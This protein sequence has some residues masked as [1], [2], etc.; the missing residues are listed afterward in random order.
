MTGKD[1]TG[2]AVLRKVRFRSAPGMIRLG[3]VYCGGGV[4]EFTVWAPYARSLDVFLTSPEG[5]HVPLTA[6]PRGYWRAA[7][8]DVYP[9]T[10]YFYRL[11]GEAERPDPASRFQPCGVHGPS[12]VT[13]PGSFPWED[14]DWKGLEADDLVFY[15]LHTGLFTPEGSFE[16]LIPHIP[17]LKDLG[18]TA[19]EL[20]P[21]AQFP[22]GRNWGYDGVY[23][24]APQ[25]TYGGPEGLKTLVNALHRNGLAVFLDVVYNHLGPEGNYTHAF[26][27][28][29]TA[30]HRTPWGEALNFEGPGSDEVR[31]FFIQN[32]LYWLEEFHMDGL[33]LDAV[34]GIV[35]RRAVHFLADLVDAVHRVTAQWDRK[36]HLVAESDLNDTR[37]I[38]PRGE[39]GYGLDAQWNDDFHHALH[40]LLTGERDGY[41]ADFGRLRHLEKAFR[42]GYVYTGQRS[43]FRRCRHGCPSAAIPGRQFVVFSQNHDQVGNRKGGDRPGRDADIEKLKLAAASVILSPYLP[44]LF[45]G[46]EYGEKAPFQYFVSFGDPALIEAV[47]RGRREEFSAFGWDGEIPDPQAEE[48]FLRS[49]LGSDR[50]RTGQGAHLLAFYRRLLQLRRE[51]PAFARACKDHLQ[52]SGDERKGLLSVLRGSSCSTEAFCLF[53]FGETTAEAEPD[54]P[55]GTWERVL[56]SSS[57][58]WG[59]KGALSPEKLCGRSSAGVPL[60]PCSVVVYV[61]CREDE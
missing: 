60:R 37:L 36:V 61:R 35:D 28:Y 50:G 33:R 31:R 23:P 24:Y 6:K 42:E 43:L 19:V 56:D 25:N 13:D 40:A 46:E 32:A 17:Y 16:A 9:G 49:K 45:M 7:V 59:G 52:V 38:F 4:T 14:A 51:S 29:F 26:G 12:E 58:E 44:L 47:C 22:G 21:A 53:H 57:A 20:M 39:G 15:E 34:H 55:G 18:I 2:E 11:N 1:V 30:Q 54:L 3:A 27:P 8:Q 5:R 10:R 41:Y 48:T